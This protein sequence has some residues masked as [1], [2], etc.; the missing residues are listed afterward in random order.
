M[1]AIG[2]FIS[3]CAVSFA[4]PV[5]AG[6]QHIGAIF[7]RWPH[8]IVSLCAQFSKHRFFQ[9]RAVSR[10]NDVGSVLLAAIEQ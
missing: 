3:S 8:E 4:K 9:Q 10:L 1:L 7:S 5:R 6:S 2:S